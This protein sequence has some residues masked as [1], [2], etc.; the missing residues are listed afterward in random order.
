MDSD[1]HCGY[2]IHTGSL[3]FSLMIA[4][5]DIETFYDCFTCVAI[6]IKTLDKYEFVIH[7]SRNDLEKFIAFVKRCKGMI[8]FNSVGFDY[9]VIHPFITDPSFL[10][11]DGHKLARAIYKR[12]QK[13]I[14]DDK[15]RDWIV[16]IV[17]QRDLYLIWHFNNKARSTSLKWL[18]IQMGFKNVVDQPFDHTQK[19]TTEMIPTVL[20]Y[21]TNDTESTIEFYHRSKDRILLRKELTERYGVDMGNYSDNKIGEF[22]FLNGIAQRTGKTVKE[23]KKIKGIVRPTIPVSEFLVD[24]DFST[25]QFRAMY[26]RFR[27]MKI[28]G[29]KKKKLTKKEKENNEE[30]ICRYDDV[31]YEFGFGGLH[32]FR[33]QGLYHNLVSADV[34]SYYPRLSI[35]LKLHP[36]QFG[37]EFC[38]TNEGLYNERREYP[39]GSA[40]NTSYKLA[41]NGVIGMTNAE[42]S[43][44]FD[45]AMNQS[46]TINGQFLLA[47]LCERITESLAGKIIMANTDGI[48]VDVQDRVAFDRICKEWQEEFN[49]QLEFNTYAKLACRDV[50]NYIGV[51]DNGKTKE[52]GMYEVEKELFKNHSKMIVPTAVRQFMINGTPIEQTI[53]NC[54]D[55]GMFLIGRRAKTGSLRYREVV[56]YELKEEVLQKNV[57]YYISRSG[58]SILKVTKET[59][60]Q[61]EKR[62]LKDT[63]KGQLSMFDVPIQEDVE[64][65][66]VTK[67][68][69]G[70]RMTVFNRWED[71]PFDEYGIEKRFY[72]DEAKQLLENAINYQTS[73]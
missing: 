29:T 32:G 4:A 58:G 63:I 24:L 17:P 16:P 42:W 43:P 19:I 2:P 64:S 13:T 36:V 69:I 6:D 47:M 10:E 71:K 28:T 73:I 72:I 61:K 44:F 20:E 37:D 68:H 59:E 39:K 21:N 48:E 41:L 45:R 5:Y 38:E 49:L 55:I 51:F 35:S 14:D 1:S 22:I 12:S 50:N 57:R 3:S 33:R 8:G 66:K 31:V 9:Y 26:E 62:K 46:V 18:Q 27:K 54:K 23:L 53:N 70:F 52:K 40:V 30:L 7:K 56:G 34:V 15:G 67:L 25:P 60:K 65:L 11:F